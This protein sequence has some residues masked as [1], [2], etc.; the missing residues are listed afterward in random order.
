MLSELMPLASEVSLVPVPSPRSIDPSKI[1]LAGEFTV[2]SQPIPKV[3]RSLRG[4]FEGLWRQDS[5][6]EAPVLLTGS[7]FLVGEALSLLSGGVFQP[8]SQ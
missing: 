8:R 1:A 7:L 3:Y 5:D 4:A 6:S 2:C